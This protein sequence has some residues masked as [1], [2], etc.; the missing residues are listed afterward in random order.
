ML[1][2]RHSHPKL[3]IRGAAIVLDELQVNC[4]KDRLDLGSYFLVVDE[5]SEKEVGEMRSVVYT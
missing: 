4:G 3:Q 5:K 1:I 2:R